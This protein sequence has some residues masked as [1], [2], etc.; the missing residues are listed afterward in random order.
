MARNITGTV[1]IEVDRCKGCGL[2][3]I[4]CPAK[5]LRISESTINAYGYHPVFVE[6]PD[7]CTG[8][9]NCFVMCPDLAITVERTSHQGADYGQDIDER[10]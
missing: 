5:I 2:C 4:S 1:F 9:S 3:T 7:E 8:C 6:R 10:Q